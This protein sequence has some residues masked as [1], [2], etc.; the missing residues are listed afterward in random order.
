MF[1]PRY[2][3]DQFTTSV[4]QAWGDIPGADETYQK[5]VGVLPTSAGKTICAALLFDAITK[6]GGR[7]IFCGDTD[8]LCAQPMEKIQRATGI[9][10]GLE[11]AGERAS[12]SADAVIGSLQTMSR[13]NRLERFPRD[14]FTHII[15][16]EA[17]RNPELH[18]KV[19]NH[20]NLAR[21][22]GITATAFRAN[23]KDLSAY[24]EYVAY[25]ME[26]FDMVN[27]GFIPP[28]KVATLPI[29]VDLSDVKQSKMFGE[30]DFNSDGLDSA[31][32]PFYEAIADAI[33]ERFMDRQIVT[34]LPLIKSSQE[35]IEICKGRGIS[36]NHVDGGSENRGQIL[37]AFER[38]EFQLIS[39]S[40][41]LSTGWDCT[42]ADTILNL[43]PTRS[44][45]LFR[46]MVGRVVRVLPGTID[47][48]PE[49]HQAKERRDAIAASAKPHA[50]I[51]D[52][53]WQTEK[54]GLTGA[55]SL[56]A[57]NEDDMREI[58][59]RVRDARD[60]EELQEIA[61]AFQEE[62]E[63]AIIA[64]LESAAR[65]KAMFV[66]AQELGALLHVPEI[67]NY[68]P[69]FRW[70]KKPVSDKQAAILFRNGIDAESI[71]SRGHACQILNEI[72][73]RKDAGETGV[74][75]IRKLL[76][77]GHR[78]AA[79]M[80]E[81][82]AQG[83]LGDSCPFPFGKHA[84][85][86]LSAVPPGYWQWLGEQAWFTAEKYPAPYAFMLARSR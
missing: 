59:K 32:R 46:Q 58:G 55:S 63:A 65:R 27:A 4:L 18:L 60:P 68:D 80:T 3:Q 78:D 38:K 37:Q 64:A 7:P 10:C 23:M 53:L 16:D 15:F 19:C 72:F 1:T 82:A 45:G 67:G 75:T 86:P 33:V 17:H 73:R 5:V 42:T 14:H 74:M 61:R 50:L 77:K 83:I 52:L 85:Q 22:L 21:V 47:H 54:F 8:E 11:K 12:L 20:F 35:F 25:K 81:V 71:K 6:A 30:S 84:G 41:L 79:R 51:I 76:E 2:Y 24:Y 62:K 34:F 49:E 36:C 57:Q 70:E 40:Q 44:V 39:N 13:A 26:M 48:L 56:I 28:I 43:R 29:D 31:I 66:D 69:E 9:F